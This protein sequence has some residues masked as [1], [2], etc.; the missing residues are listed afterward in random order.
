[1]KSVILCEKERKGREQHNM[2]LIK[3]ELGLDSIQ[4]AKFDLINEAFYTT[5]IDNHD[6]YHGKPKVY[7]QYYKEID[8]N[9]KVAFKELMTD[10]Q[11]NNYLEL[12]KK[13]NF[14]KSED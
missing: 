3:A 4:N 14:G 7:E 10:D 5:L 2:N 12:V 8:V 6:N 9:R 13:Y 11:Y 1:M